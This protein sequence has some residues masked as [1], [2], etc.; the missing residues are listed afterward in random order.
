MFG[1]PM[2]G[3]ESV[4]FIKLKIKRKVWKLPD[5]QKTACIFSRP[6]AYHGVDTIDGEIFK[7]M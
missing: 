7:I 4:G 1:W 2:A 5:T 6:H 3:P